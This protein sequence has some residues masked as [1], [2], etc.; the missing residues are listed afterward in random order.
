MQEKKD[1]WH[2]CS[3]ACGDR[4]FPPKARTH[5]KRISELPW[6]AANAEDF[7]VTT[8]PLPLLLAFVCFYYH[9]YQSL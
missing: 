7:E 9:S 6:N 4:V 5:L 3:C 1:Q 8:A 2:G